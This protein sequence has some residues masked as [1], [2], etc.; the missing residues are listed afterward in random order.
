[1]SNDNRGVMKIP[2]DEFASVSAITARVGGTAGIKY[3]TIKELTDVVQMDKL[4]DD[5]ALILFKN[6]DLKT[7]PLP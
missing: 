2:T 3:E 7:V 4:N 5:N 1:M 6:G